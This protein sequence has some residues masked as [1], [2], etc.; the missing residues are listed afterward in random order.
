MSSPTPALPENVPTLS[1]TCFT[2]VDIAAKDF[3]AATLVAGDNGKPKL[4][5]KPFPQ[6][7]AGFARFLARLATARVTPQQHLIVME[8]TGPYWVSLAVT[9][10]QAGYAVSVV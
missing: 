6:D 1:F 10:V 9:L 5:K 4:E 7:P 2:G 3:T 8:S